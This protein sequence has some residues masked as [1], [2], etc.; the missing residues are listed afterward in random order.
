MNTF[1]YKYAQLIV[2]TNGQ[3]Q[4]WTQSHDLERFGTLNCIEFLSFCFG[5]PKD[6][7]QSLIWS[8]SVSF[9]YV[10]VG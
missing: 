1:L 4:I 3:A 6:K 7:S 9:I 8:V 2:G 10:R 5:K